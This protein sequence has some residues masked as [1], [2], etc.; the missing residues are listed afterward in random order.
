MPFQVFGEQ[1]MIRISHDP[2]M[3][4]SWVEDLSCHSGR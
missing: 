4:A 2:V 3:G 1:I